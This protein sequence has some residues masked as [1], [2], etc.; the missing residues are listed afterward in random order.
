MSRASLLAVGDP[1][2]AAHVQ[3]PAGHEIRGIGGD[4][5]ASHHDGDAIAQ[6]VWRKGV[7]QNVATRTT[8]RGL[9]Q[10]SGA[11]LQPRGQVVG[12]R[13]TTTIYTHVL[14]RGLAGAQLDLY[15]ETHARP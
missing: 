15:L 13:R 2:C 14:N 3:R 6:R 5:A 12:L 4:D 1:R 11:S 7:L 10:L 9:G 8:I